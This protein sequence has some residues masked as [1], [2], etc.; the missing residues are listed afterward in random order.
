MD[1]DAVMAE[2]AAA[3]AL[4]MKYYAM[5]LSPERYMRDEAARPLAAEAFLRLLELYAGALRKLGRDTFGDVSASHAP[6]SEE[7]DYC[8]STPRARY[9][10]TS[11]LAQGQFSTVYSGHRN[12]RPEDRVIIKIADGMEESA[13]L[14]LEVQV[15][16]Q[17]HSD[18]SPLRIHLPRYLDQFKTDDGRTGVILSHADG[19]TIDEIRQLYSLG[20]PPVHVIWVMRRLLSVLGYAHSRGILHGN[21]T[22]EHVLVRPWDHNVVL[23]DWSCAVVNPA[24][25]GEGFKFHHPVYSAPEVAEQKPP[26]PSADLYSLGLCMITLLGG[27]AKSQEMPASVDI[28]LQRFIKFFVRSS[29][30]GRAQDAWEM[31]HKLKALRDEIFGTHQFREF[32]MKPEGVTEAIS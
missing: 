21:V 1:S 26:L 13:R 5:E 23:L 16:R 22:P 14:Q 27:D 17:L 28:R 7:V 15:L 29:P 3:F 20:M 8:I 11:G 9:D 31:F 6:D 19:Y 12:Q 25:T 4:Q 10:V 32:I 2:R 18:T 30:I 24:R